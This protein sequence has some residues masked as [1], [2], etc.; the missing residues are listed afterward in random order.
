MSNN[1]LSKTGKH[2]ARTENMAVAHATTGSDL[3]DQFS[4]AGS[5]RGRDIEQVFADQ[6]TLHNTDP[7]KALQFVF[8]LRLVSRKVKYFDERTENVQ[9]GQGN[10]DESFKRFLWYA[11]NHSD[12]FYQNV[13]LFAAVGRFQDFFDLMWEA[14]NHDIMLDNHKMLQLTFDY[15]ET[16]GQID[17]LKK[18]MPLP[19]ASSKLNTPRAKFMNMV[20]VMIRDHFGWEDREMRKFK[21]SGDAHEWQQ[22][23]SKQRFA[24]INFDHVPGRAL[25]IMAGGDF[26]LNNDLIKQYQ[27]WLEDQPVAKFTGY[28]YEL[29]NRV[30]YNMQPYQK[31]TVD[32]QFEGLI[33]L[34]SRDEG[35]IGGNVWCALDTSGSMGFDSAKVDDQ[36]T[37][38]LTV[39][40]SLGIYFST[41][42]QG[43]FHKNVI[44][45]DSNS[46]V[47][48]L[49]GSFTDMWNQ[50]T[51]STTAWGSTNFLSV[52]DEIVRVRSNNPEK[53]VPLEDYPDTLVVISDMQFNPSGNKNTNH[54]EAMRRLA[55]VF[56]RDWVE[57]FRVIWWDVVGRRPDNHPTHID[58]GGT[59]VFSG[60]DGAILSLLLG[61]DIKDPETGEK[62][63]KTLEESIDDA[64]NQ[65]ILQQIQL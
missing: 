14:F 20:A 6:S 37:L 62:R 18:Y 48:E 36:G 31:M 35:A 64:L 49:K 30:S 52:I 53:M 16:S 34:A 23:I 56:P 26:L 28:P 43:E 51:N 7:L 32:K 39:C 10:R 2:S 9:R 27:D 3:A 60:F 17:L 21:T 1:F 65:E 5:Y 4:K 13:W 57:N 41:L 29:G 50:I 61:G 38:A 11:V 47:K 8:Y 24:E 25:S 42:N 22:K 15:A 40:L 46:R 33:E 55:T 59:Y 44:M 19:R 54:E 12:L 58:E 45:F 63:S